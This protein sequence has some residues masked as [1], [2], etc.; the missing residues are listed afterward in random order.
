M[1]HGGARA[2]A[3]PLPDPNALRRERPED[4]ARWRVLSE[5]RKGRAPVWPLTQRSRRELTLWNRLWKL[6]QAVMWDESGQH[7]QVALYVRRFTEA[8]KPG[9]AVNLSTLIRQQEEAL[10]LSL[11]GLLMRRWRIEPSSGSAGP[12]QSRAPRRS[13][14]E[15][16][17]VVR[18]DD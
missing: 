5:G 3:G 7:T 1:A 12:K 8:E 10:G 4:V 11:P 17:T 2:S 15:R 16:L 18:E 13:S 6:P 9:S 14:R